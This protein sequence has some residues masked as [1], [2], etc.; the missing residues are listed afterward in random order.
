MRNFSVGCQ[1]RESVTPQRFGRTKS[2]GAT[3]GVSEQVGSGAE[4]QN[5]NITT[6]FH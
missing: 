1:T 6:R 4:V 5:T 2:E 3:E